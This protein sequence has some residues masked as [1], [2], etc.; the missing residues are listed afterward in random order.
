MELHQSPKNSFIIYLYRTLSI[1]ASA[2]F[3]IP[4]SAFKI[5]HF[6]FKNAFAFENALMP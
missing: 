2:K 1:F 5:L 6:A 3:Y 4:R